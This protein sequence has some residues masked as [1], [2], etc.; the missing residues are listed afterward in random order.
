MEQPLPERSEDG[1]DLT[2][3]RWMLSLTPAERLAVLQRFV[4]SV[5]ELRELNAGH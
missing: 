2:L 1:I 5:G 4:R 3:I